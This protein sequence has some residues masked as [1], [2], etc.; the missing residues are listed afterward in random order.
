M[1]R[2]SGLATH[3]GRRDG[4]YHEER[5]A[6]GCIELRSSPALVVIL[7]PTG[8]DERIG[9]ANWSAEDL[10]NDGRATGWEVGADR[11]QGL[12]SLPYPFTMVVCRRPVESFADINAG[13]RKLKYRCREVFA[14]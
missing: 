2:G 11:R 13:V 14:N 8:R 10:S 4:Q 3:R 1:F 6:F 5:V 12:L 9:A 7:S